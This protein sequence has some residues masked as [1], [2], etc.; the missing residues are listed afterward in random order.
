MWLIN[1]STL[2]AIK[3]N[4]IILSLT[5]TF[6]YL[7]SVFKRK[8][9]ILLSLIILNS[10]L[11]LVG[12]AAILPILA[13]TLKPGFI[14]SNTFL[15]NFYNHL[16][17]ESTK[18]FVVFLC[19]IILCFV[20]LKNIFGLWV[21]KQQTKISLDAYS[22]LSNN[23]LKSAFSK[24][25]LFFSQDNSNRLANRIVGVPMN[26][27]T[28]LLPQLFLF[29]NEIVILTLIIVS[30]LVYEIKVLLILSI[31]ILPVF[32]VFYNKNKT[33]VTEAS[34]ELN[35]LSPLIWRPVFEV[36]FG[37]VD[38]VVGNVFKNFE[39]KY[40]NQID[41][42]KPLRIKLSVIQQIPNR[43]IEVCVVLTVI[44]MLMYGL[45]YLESPE[46]IIGM[47]S[48]FGLAAYRTIPSINR[49]MLSLVNIR[50]QTYNFDLLDEFLPF[51]PNKQ[52][53]NQLEFKNKISLQNIS[54][55]FPETPKPTLENYSLDINK[56]EIIGVVGKSGSGKTTLM[57]ILLGF[58]ELKSGNFLVD[59]VEINTQN[60]T[61]WHQKVGYVPQDVFL[62][63][64]SVVE[65]IAFGIPPDEVSLY[66]LNTCIQ[67]ALL[68]DMINELSDGIH[69]RIGERGS[70]I[71]GGQRQRMGIA[72]ALYHN[73]EILFFDEATSALDSE[74]ETEIT[75]A[76]NSLH[77][78]NLTMVIIAHRKSSL[79]YCDRIIEIKPIS[80]NELA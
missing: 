31:V 70:R 62:I 72:R 25:Y 40:V 73:A 29:L 32:T 42:T 71:S 60:I 15:N 12:L 8:G 67:K 17:F 13:A 19:C 76:I 33:R 22:I 2:S 80:Q 51:T 35:D 58:L 75:D 39:K 34:K 77:D 47:L 27:C 14:E 55:Q 36:V 49:L 79:K 23:V 18:F 52:T 59:D 1:T 65:N 69:T 66:K 4:V 50:A 45:F 61:S 28:I 44:L 43:L 11:E 10:F 41:N 20:I 68:T 56:G 63:D 78:S 16:G 26:I 5:K 30:L 74:T 6:G 37:F 54:F 21:Q 48:I 24:G 38:V 7:P 3:Q 46:Q 9:I 57:N 64:G 53:E